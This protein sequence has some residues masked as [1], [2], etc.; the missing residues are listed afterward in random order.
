MESGQPIRKIAGI[1][2]G[3]TYSAIAHFDEYG[4]A[5]V[6]P[7]SENER[8]TPSVVLFEDGQAVVGKTAKNLAIASPKHVVQFVKR[9]MGEPEWYREIDGQR[10]TPE[11]ISAMI[12]RRLVSDAEIQLSQQITDV[13]IT[14]PAY[15]TD[16]ERRL[17][18]E[19]GRIAGLNV[20]GIL[21]E[22]TA[23]AVAYG[24]TNM[25]ED[26]TALVFDLGG[27]TFDVTILRVRGNDV[28]V[29]A[30]DGERRLGGK[31]WDDALIE[32][33]ADIFRRKFGVDPRDDPQALQ[34]LTIRAE[35]AKKALSTKP[36]TKLFVQCGGEQLKVEVTREKYAEL[37]APLL[38]RVEARLDAVLSKAGMTWDQIDTV[39]RVGGMTRLPEVE[40]LLKGKLAGKDRKEWVNPDECV[41][42]GAAYWAAIQ[43]IR[44]SKRLASQVGTDPSLRQ[45][46]ELLQRS[47][48]DSIP[49]DLYVIL[50]QSMVR[51]VNSHSLGV[52]TVGADDAR[53][54]EI[55]IPEQTP[56]PHEVTREFVTA[57]DGQESVQIKILEGAS[58]DPSACTQLGRCY[59]S[60]L[61]A[62]RPK[63]SRVSV[64]YRYREDGV[65]EIHA[66]DQETGK[67]VKTDI[68]RTAD[69]M[70]RESAELERRRVAHL[71][72]SANRDPLLDSEEAVREMFQEGYGYDEDVEGPASELD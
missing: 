26:V 39:L 49:A 30:T 7:N 56:I 2:L 51:N 42:T 65:V 16:N 48:A 67:E 46:H 5:E 63:G 47:L 17:T 12:I 10:F 55:M 28:R 36:R 23:A 59:I 21:N 61:P 52:L 60:G 11:V 41:A 72:E 1:D 25:K 40:R 24:L 54:N 22:P 44:E 13:V 50:E 68:R 33:V 18:A 3:T 37:T 27:G 64:T 43:M 6:I 70:D 20:L 14:C 35:E 45:E 34:D 9:H 38:A 58:S 53:V 66:R 15:F 62:G 71:L 4:R 32:R 31:D 29:V 57:Y 8:T 69:V 19:A